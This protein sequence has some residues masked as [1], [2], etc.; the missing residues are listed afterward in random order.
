NGR[1]QA[2]YDYR[3]SSHADAFRDGT[4]KFEQTWPLT[5]DTDTHI[6][7]VAAGEGLTLG[8]VV[9]PDHQDDIP[10]AVSNPIYV[11]VGADGFQPNG[12]ML[13]PPLPLAGE[14]NE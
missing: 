1:P 8:P 4:V 12:D 3:R 11:D 7:V 2:E 10:I 5:F 9:G 13:G 6:V 14:S